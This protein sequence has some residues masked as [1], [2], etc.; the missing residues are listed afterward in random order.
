MR[1]VATPGSFF[2]GDPSGGPPRDLL[3]VANMKNHP[4][5]EKSKTMILAT[6][7]AK[8]SLVLSLPTTTVSNSTRTITNHHQKKKKIIGLFVENINLED[9][10][11]DLA[12]RYRNVTS[13]RNVLVNREDT[14]LSIRP[15]FPFFPSTD[16][17]ILDG[18]EEEF[19]FTNNNHSN[20]LPFAE[21]LD[22]ISAALF[23]GVERVAE[24]NDDFFGNLFWRIQQVGDVST[25]LEKV[26]HA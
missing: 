21:V 15:S 11:E 20:P 17:Y 10:L 14:F 18:D 1:L 5:P 4:V 23:D 26:D 13:S 24:W 3:L 12:L 19:F 22:R 7:V 16:K 6:Q 2:V 25:R 8:P 9:C